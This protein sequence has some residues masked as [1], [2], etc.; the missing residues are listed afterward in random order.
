MERLHTLILALVAAIAA[1]SFAPSA[2]AQL[3]TTDGTT[4]VADPD[5]ELPEATD[6]ELSSIDGESHTAT[7]LYI[8]S[9]LLLLGEHELA[10]EQVEERPRPL[11]A[12]L[13]HARSALR[14]KAQE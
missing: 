5:D 14:A 2:H 12:D 8:T 10:A 7:A 4:H 1:F 13:H 6:A 9:P 11:G 3:L